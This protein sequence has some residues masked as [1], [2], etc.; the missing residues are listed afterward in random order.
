MDED[1]QNEPTLESLTL[2]I[3]QNYRMVEA[4]PFIE[5]WDGN[6]GTYK[7]PKTF[8]QRESGGLAQLAFGLLIALHRL[9]QQGIFCEG[10][11]H[12]IGNST[13]PFLALGIALNADKKR[14]EG[15]WLKG[16]FGYDKLDDEPISGEQKELRRKLNEAAESIIS[17]HFDGG[18]GSKL[19]K[20]DGKPT[21]EPMVD[22]EIN[23]LNISYHSSWKS[24]ENDKKGNG[25]LSELNKD[26]LLEYA[27]RTIEE[28]QCLKP[29]WEC[30]ELIDS[31]EGLRPSAYDSLPSKLKIWVDTLTNTPDWNII[32]LLFSPPVPIEDVYCELQLK[33]KSHRLSSVA[34]RSADSK[35]NSLILLESM[36][37]NI[38]RKTILVGE[39]GSGKTTIIKWIAHF[40]CNDLKKHDPIYGLYPVVVSLAEYVHARKGETN[41]TLVD[42]FLNHSHLINDQ[43]IPKETITN[44]ESNNG[45]SPLFLLDGWDE[46]PAQ[47]RYSI[48]LEIKKLSAFSKTLITSRVTGKPEEVSEGA[49]VYCEIGNLHSTAIRHL[50]YRICE[51]SNK[52]HT[53]N[54]ILELLDQNKSLANMTTNAFSLSLICQLFMEGRSTLDTVTTTT[55]LY[56]QATWVMY[57]HHNSNLKI[58]NLTP[59]CL[60][61][62]TFAALSMMV[63][64]PERILYG[65][66]SLLGY[67]SEEFFFESSLAKS[68]F[69]SVHQFPSGA[70]F[71]FV[72]LKMLEFRAAQKL[73]CSFGFISEKDYEFLWQYGA[74]WEMLEVWKFYAGLILRRKDTTTQELHFCNYWRYM[75]RELPDKFGG[76]YCYLAFVMSEVRKEDRSSYD[77]GINLSEKLWDNIMR[78][79]WERLSIKAL[80][81]YDPRFL[82]M[83][84][85]EHDGVDKRFM[86]VVHEELPS[87]LKTGSIT[88]HLVSSNPIDD[89]DPGLDLQFDGQ[90]AAPENL[91]LLRSEIYKEDASHDSIITAFLK[92]HPYIDINS[93]EDS[94]VVLDLPTNRATG[95]AISVLAKIGGSKC[96][97][98]LAK[99]L[100]DIL[101][102]E[103]IFYTKKLELLLTIFN[104]G[105]IKVL[106]AKSV[107]YLMSEIEPNEPDSKANYQIMSTLV[108]TPVRTNIEKVLQI[109]QKTTV[110]YVR[111]VASKLLLNSGHTQS[112]KQ[113]IDWLLTLDIFDDSRREILE[114]ISYNS[115]DLGY[116]SSHIITAIAKGLNDFEFGRV[117]HTCLKVMQYSHLSVSQKY[118]LFNLLLPV[119][120]WWS[121]NSSFFEKV[122]CIVD[123]IS[124][125]VTDDQKRVCYSYIEKILQDPRADLYQKEDAFIII[126]RLKIPESIG[127]LV[128]SLDSMPTAHSKQEK[129]LVI[130]LIKAI[131]DIDEL[132]IAERSLQ[133]HPNKK[134]ML[135]EMHTWTEENLYFL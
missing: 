23:K 64:K 122:M 123:L 121:K 59:K 131:L 42:Y 78:G 81:Q 32:P 22:K 134:L 68:R 85:L 25:G 62:M 77:F 6:G 11:K 38:G 17:E 98:I 110:I 8:D 130:A 69:I 19:K 10:E 35:G 109:F 128:S 45:L 30:R 106:E 88:F 107:A 91:D 49:D 73:A 61:K 129:A 34:D 83:K 47:E 67:D 100:I 96:A 33:D 5:D 24:S 26:D 126:S 132:K 7:K 52:S 87:I 12:F 89:D 71:S 124:I 114:H 46:V 105:K 3:D 118:D 57:E 135:L 103:Q 113:V 102:Q 65:E 44:L 48:F 80:S 37:S 112:A 133:D 97:M 72:H 63:A 111:T 28:L 99:E 76:I 95:I 41:I 60:E 9:K 56:E 74:K 79:G 21:Y 29:K 27:L 18:T 70:G 94:Q 31:L 125:H 58:P 117:P 1:H 104:N 84:I 4:K 20:W 16:I 90:L 75:L 86:R 51:A 40:L 14:K 115:I 82:I 55:E 119:I 2:Y 127:Y 66:I 53:A 116:V 108:F 39:P 92:I 13:T 101:K 36:L 43:D 120:E 15:L 54:Q 50:V 93:V